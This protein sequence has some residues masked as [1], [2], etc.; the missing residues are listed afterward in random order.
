MEIASEPL[1]DDMMN[2]VDIACRG[3]DGSLFGVLFLNPHCYVPD[4]AGGKENYL[5]R[6]VELKIQILTEVFG[7]TLLAVDQ[8]DFQKMTNADRE[9]YLLERLTAAQDPPTPTPST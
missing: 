7:W 3:S 6:S 8:A 2:L 9:T 5:R 4:L 1:S